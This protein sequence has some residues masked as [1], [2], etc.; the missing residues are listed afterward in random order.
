MLEI[1]W[2]HIIVDGYKI[3]N[4]CKSLSTQLQFLDL[5][6]FPHN[7]FYGGDF[8]CCH[9]DWGYNDNIADGECLTGWAS[10][11]SLTLLYKCQGCHQLLL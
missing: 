8:N 11:N 2:L 3:V 10:I 5:P 6:V 9:I 1:E 7:C 4:I